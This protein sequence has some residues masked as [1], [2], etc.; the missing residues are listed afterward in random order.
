M[1]RKEAIQNHTRNVSLS[2]YAE[3]IWVKI[4]TV[5]RWEDIPAKYWRKSIERLESI[6]DDWMQ[7][8]DLFDIK[9][10]W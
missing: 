4:E 3:Y 9:K 2:A 10:F 6:G 5:S 8:V 7:I 1:N